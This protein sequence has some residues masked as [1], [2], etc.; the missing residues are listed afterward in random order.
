MALR[1]F[2]LTLSAS[3]KRVSDVYGGAASVRDAATDITYR[4]LLVQATGAD[5]YLGDSTAVS[6][7]TGMKLTA[8]AAPVSIGP[9]DSGPIKLSDL[10]GIGAG[11]TLQVVGV[12]F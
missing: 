7:A 8:G 2:S 3:A 4:Q 1:S 10:W 12:P 5:A 11:A 6:A 9:F